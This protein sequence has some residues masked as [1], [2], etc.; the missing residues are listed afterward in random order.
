[1]IPAKTSMPEVTRDAPSVPRVYQLYAALS[2]LESERFAGSLGGRLVLLGKL[3]A[4]GAAAALAAS[5]AGA[6]SLAIDGDSER[7]KAAL[8]TG[9]CD[10]VVNHLDEALRIL[11]NEIRK[12]QPVAVGLS[13][14]PEAVLAEMAERGVQPDVLAVQDA[15]PL[16]RKFAERGALTLPSLEPSDAAG[17]AV[18]WT[19]RQAPATWLPRADALAVQSLEGASEE[20]LRW[21][22][23]APRYLGRTLHARRYLRMTL[24]ERERFRERLRDLEV[25]GVPQVRIAD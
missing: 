14:M 2:R 7:L 18:E 9:I 1:M 19:A 8:R 17:I 24:P 23:L 5:I 15:G 11:K 20:R 22:R 4:E 12:K 6:A 16:T 3:D 25:D 13:A 21:L 10:F